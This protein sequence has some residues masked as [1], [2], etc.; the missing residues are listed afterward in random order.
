MT[1]KKANSRVL[2]LYVFLNPCGVPLYVNLFL[3]ITDSLLH[4][5]SISD[6]ICEL[7]KTV[8]PEQR[9]KVGVRIEMGG[10]RRLL[11]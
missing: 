9:L 5:S 2:D 11:Y 10:D 1:F 4:I 7:K 3:W 6:K 8:F